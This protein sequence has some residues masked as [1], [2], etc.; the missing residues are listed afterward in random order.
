MRIALDLSAVQ[1]TGT[2]VYSLGFLSAL[3]KLREPEDEFIV[4]APKAIQDLVGPLVGKD[5]QFFGTS[6]LSTVPYRLWWQQLVLPQL[7]SSLKIDVL[8]AAFD[9]APWRCGCPIV[10][11]IRNPNPITLVTRKASLSWADFLKRHMHQFIV[12]GSCYRASA[13]VFPSHYAANAVG[14]LL[15][16]PREKR[17][18][19]NHG[20]DVEFWLDADQ[21]H[22]E[23]PAQF[24]L[25]SG[26]YILFASQ[27]YP[28]KRAGLL[29]EAFHGWRQSFGRTGY[30]LVYCGEDVN[31]TRTEELRRRIKVLG[32]ETDVKLLGIVDR[33]TLRKLYR[34]ACEFVLP[35]VLET[36]GF[37]YV[38]TMASQIPLVC[39]DIEV[40][41]EIC[42]D[43]AYYFQPDDRDSLIA[44]METALQHPA[45]RTRKLAIGVE[46]ARNFSWRKEAEETLAC[47]KA[48]AHGE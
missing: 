5:Y 28:Q 17:K 11:C 27:F 31:S 26:K 6:A 8:F 36:F 9:L 29:L 2:R 39:A 15:G 33:T 46:R 47:I 10:L 13:L 16:V 20:L 7:I 18:V 45:T 35:T 21:S 25:T 37:G 30:K 14:D 3:A 12:R 22:T 23:L 48:A 42:G 38:E 41:R 32:L 24:G 40:A 44:A 4:F 34:D 19:V 43:A 1:T